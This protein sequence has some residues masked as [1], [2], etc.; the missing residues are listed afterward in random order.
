[1]RR[2]ITPFV[3]FLWLFGCQS[4]Q[5]QQVIQL[6]EGTNVRE[7]ISVD[8]FHL[9]QSEISSDGYR[10]FVSDSV[11]QASAHGRELVAAMLGR[12]LKDYYARIFVLGKLVSAPDSKMLSITDSLFTQNQKTDLFY[13]IVF[14]KSMNG[15]DGFYSEALG[16]SALKFL[17]SKTETFADY[18]NIAP[19]LDVT[20][21]DNWAS[22]V[23][24][25]IMISR[26]S[27]E[28]VAINELETELLE[29][30]KTARKEDQVIV[31]LFLRKLKMLNDSKHE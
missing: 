27:E 22:C 7:L 9:D 6:K 20:D 24:S 2:I 30:I 28:E 8:S 25:E 15:A 17:R 23:Y 29:N 12:N 5:E 19:K 13:F 14:T 31:S 4:S 1:M 26:E 3:C 10:A 11:K 16:Q 21:L 18:F